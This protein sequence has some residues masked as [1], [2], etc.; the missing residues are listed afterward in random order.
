MYKLEG[1][2]SAAETMTQ[3]ITM[4]T[5]LLGFTVTFASEFTPEAADLSVPLTLICS[6]GL[7]VLAIAAAFWALL[8]VT[9]SINTAEDGAS[10]R[11]DAMARNIQIPAL[12]S[13]GAFVVAIILMVIAGVSIVR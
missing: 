13:V 3:L 4:A 11:A 1:A 6:W 7:F 5:A 10:G 12:I 2:K 8:A 9:G